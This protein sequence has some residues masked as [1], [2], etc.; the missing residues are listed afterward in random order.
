M[1]IAHTLGYDRSTVSR[2]TK[3]LTNQG[4]ILPNE[5]GREIEFA[6][7]QK[8][9]KFLK[10]ANSCLNKLDRTT[11]QLLGVNRSIMTNLLTANNK[12][13]DRCIHE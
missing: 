12:R 3:V 13:I 5:K 4:Y 9:E 2:M 10:T 1:E 7:T 6:I 11:S 8:G